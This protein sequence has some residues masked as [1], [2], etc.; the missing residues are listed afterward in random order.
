MILRR[1]SLPDWFR[2]LAPF[3]PCVVAG[4]AGYA[5]NFKISSVAQDGADRIKMR[6]ESDTNSYF[7]LRG[8]ATLTSI[9][10]ITSFA[11]GQN[12]DGE[13]SDTNSLKTLSTRFYRLQRVPIEAALDSDGEGDGGN[14]QEQA[15]HRY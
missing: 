10:Q 9:N 7:I 12:G 15:F 4:W 1:F 8:G 11:L 14:G 13:V 6:Y 2:F 3:L 5:A